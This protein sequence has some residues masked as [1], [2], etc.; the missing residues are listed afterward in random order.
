MALMSP[1][2]ELNPVKPQVAQAASVAASSPVVSGSNVASTSR[3]APGTG[4]VSFTTAGNNQAAKAT[5]VKPPTVAANAGRVSFDTQ[6]LDPRSTVEGRMNSL[7]SRDSAYR[8]QAETQA[9][10]ASNARGLMNSSMAVT[11]GQSAALQ[12]MLPIAQQ[13][14][15]TYFQNDQ[16]NLAYTNEGRKLNAGTELDIAKTNAAADQR[17]QE[18]NAQQFAENEAL[19]A[20][21]RQEQ[22]QFNT[23]QLNEAAKLNAGTALDIAKSNADADNRTSQFNAELGTQN[24][25]FNAQQAQQNNQFNRELTTQNNQFNAAS[26]NEANAAYAEAVNRQNFEVLQGRVKDYLANV[27]ANL[28]AGLNELEHTY[29]LTEQMDSVMGKAYQQLIDGISTIAAS[30]D[31]GQVAKDKIEFMLN[32]AGAIFEF[33]D[34]GTVNVTNDPNAVNPAPGTANNPLPPTTITQPDG[35]T[36]QTGGQKIAPGASTSGG[37]NT[38]NSSAAA[39]AVDTQAQAVAQFEANNDWQALQHKD[40]PGWTPQA[41]YYDYRFGFMTKEARDKQQAFDNTGGG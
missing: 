21:L 8:Q 18:F 30:E 2:Q 27:D 16:N 5:P 23:G 14:A 28:Q 20:G 17:G 11:A 10:Q 36:M 34:G 15:S 6:A 41:P 39:T 33:S 26:Q 25:Q 9:K 22:S 35:S 40:R 38:G 31:D 29:R 4:Q 19:N 7:M 13:D 12:A 3:V 1:P 37:M 24:S 32:K